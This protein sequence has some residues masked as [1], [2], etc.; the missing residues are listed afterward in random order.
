MDTLTLMI[1][2]GVGALLLLAGFMQL[3][4]SFMARP[5]V[6]VMQQS[7]D[8]SG[9]GCAAALLLLIAAI[10]AAWALGLL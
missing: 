7:G 10:A 4:W 8:E 3:R 9:L 2:G 5:T 1:L 6:V